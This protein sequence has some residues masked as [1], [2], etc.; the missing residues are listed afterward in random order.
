MSKLT[1]RVEIS[2]DGR[3]IYEEAED[4]EEVRTL[5]DDEVVAAGTLALFE[6]KETVEGDSK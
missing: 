3:T 5:S 2:R 1:V 6:A 4:V